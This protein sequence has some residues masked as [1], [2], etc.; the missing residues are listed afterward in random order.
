MYLQLKRR[1][2]AQALRDVASGGTGR[3]RSSVRFH[4]QKTFS[5]FTQ[6]LWK[7]EDMVPVRRSMKSNDHGVTNKEVHVRHPHYTWSSLIFPLFSCTNFYRLQLTV[8]IEGNFVR[9]ES[10]LLLPVVINKA[11][12]LKN[13]VPNTRVYYTES[14]DSQYGNQGVK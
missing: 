13:S 5:L 2:S 11:T 10:L 9:H 4:R 3:T 6:H 1:T 7:D 8:F 14:R 12:H